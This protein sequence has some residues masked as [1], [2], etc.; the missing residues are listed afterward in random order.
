MDDPLPNGNTPPANG[1]AP[2][3]PPDGE[4]APGCWQLPGLLLRLCFW[5]A[6]LALIV[7]FLVVVLTST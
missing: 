6:M 7:W 3:S 2:A 4:P 5:L 1:T